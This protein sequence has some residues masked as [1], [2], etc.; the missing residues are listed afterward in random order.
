V[1]I[2]S[3]LRGSDAQ[4]AVVHGTSMP[5]GAPLNIASRQ[6]FRDARNASGT[7]IGLPLRSRVSG[8]RVIPV[9]RALRHA[10]GSFAGVVDVNLDMA[11][12]LRTFCSIDT[13]PHGTVALFDSDRRICFRQP[14][15]AQHG[16]E[17]LRRFEGQRR[18]RC[19]PAAAPKCAS[20]P[21]AARSTA[22]PGW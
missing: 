9:A 20:R 11:Q 17:Q 5:A 18:C 13:G 22:A 8:E 19:W 15:P 4:G 1:P 7:V 2:S 6:F 3:G 10:D 16:D 21:P 12:V 14:E